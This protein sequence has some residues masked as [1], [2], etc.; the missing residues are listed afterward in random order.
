M[1]ATK[2]PR[3]LAG[4]L[5]IG[6]TESYLTQLEQQRA[7]QAQD[8]LLNLVVGA[9]KPFAKGANILAKGYGD[10]Y[11]GL[12]GNTDY[13]SGAED[14]IRSGITDEEHQRIED[15]PYREILKSGA[16]MASRLAPFSTAGVFTNPATAGTRAFDMVNFSSNPLVNQTAQMGARGVL[17][18]M[19]QGYGDSDP[20]NELRDTLRSGA[21]G[22]GAEIGSGYLFDKNYRDMLN[23]EVSKGYKSYMD[24]QTI[25]DPRTGRKSF[26][27]SASL[28]SKIDDGIDEL[29]IMRGKA[30]ESAGLDR[31]TI[32]KMDTFYEGI[33]GRD[34]LKDIEL[35]QRGSVKKTPA[36]RDYLLELRKRGLVDP[37]QVD[38]ILRLEY[39]IDTNSLPTF[40]Q[41]QGDP[42]NV[43]TNTR[44]GN[45]TIENND[46]LPEIDIFEDGDEGYAKLVRQSNA[47]KDGIAQGAG[48]N[49]KGANEVQEAL[50]QVREDMGEELAKA[51]ININSLRPTEDVPTG[52][53][54]KYIQEIKSGKQYPLIV[55]AYIDES[56]G[57]PTSGKWVFDIVD[58]NHRYKAYKELGI[59]DIPIIVNKSGAKA[60][61][62]IGKTVQVVEPEKFSI[63]SDLR[64]IAENSKSR[65][66][67]SEKLLEDWDK[68]RDEINRIKGTF[69]EA[70]KYQYRS[71]LDYIWEKIRGA[72][73]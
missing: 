69:N 31:K 55:E 18:G 5:G 12:S 26:K 46:N 11:R 73:R 47:R 4:T 30:I 22:A 42:E 8:T 36:I 51:N 66:E 27:A 37:G 59:K 16:G 2:Q 64:K 13:V 54:D 20:G 43:L 25:I 39:G 40:K 23:D 70:Q 68:Y 1:E 6:D 48:D 56:T 57:L 34:Y 9:T 45:I 17:E 41:M 38:F 33:E 62:N 67:F 3:R 65:V 52:N 15:N 32:N 28:P 35:L 14:Y 63:D 21:L 60:T 58:G 7:K 19:L 44:S 71:V 49:L 61:S 72:R 53:I 50:Q 24:N 10:L 29:A